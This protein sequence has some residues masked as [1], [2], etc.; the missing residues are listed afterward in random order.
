MKNGQ[1]GRRWVSGLTGLVFLTLVILVATLSVPGEK[2]AIATHAQPC[3]DLNGDGLVTLADVEI[4]ASYILMAVP[5]APSQVD[6]NQ[7]GEITGDDIIMVVDALGATDLICQDKPVGLQGEPSPTLTPV[8]TNTQTPTQTPTQ[9]QTPTPTPFAAC[10]DMELDGAITISDISIMGSYVLQPVPPAPARLDFNGNGFIDI[11]ELVLVI[12]Q[13]GQPPVNCTGLNPIGAKPTPTPLP[14]A[15]GVPTS[16]PAPTPTPVDFCADMNLDGAVTISDISI[17]ASY[18]LQPVPPAPARLDFNGDNFIAISELVLVIGQFGQLPVNCTGLDPIGAKPTPTPTST[19]TATPTVIPTSTPTSTPTPTPVNFCADM[20]LDGAVTIS[21]I[22]IMASYVLQPVPPAPARLDFNGNAF[23]DIGELVLVVGQFGQLPVNCEG[24]DPV[25][26][27]GAPT[28]TPTTPP[29]PTPTPTPTLT[30]TPTPTPTPTPTITPTPTTTPTPT[31]TPTPTPFAACVD[32]DLL[33]GINEID[34]R[35]VASYF[36]QLAPPAP[37]RVDINGDGFVTIGDV[38]LVVQQVGNE[39][40]NCAGQVPIGFKPPPTPTPTATAT[41]TP[42]P[43]PFCADINGDGIVTEVDAYIVAS[44]FGQV[45]PPAPVTVDLNRD[46]YVTI[47]DISFVVSQV[48][49][50]TACQNSPAGFNG[51]PWDVDTSGEVT[52]ID[53]RLVLKADG[54]SPP[55]NLL[56]DVNGDG[57]VSAADALLVTDHFGELCS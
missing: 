11:S 19:P 17:M 50:T 57:I 22:S 8:P 24:L 36:G 37:D 47:S 45:V 51:C 27:K 28:P 30:L 41:P 5:A 31:L 33:N 39:P 6:L 12:G 16:T 18:V 4:V 26:F 32:M 34:V 9:T 35:I 52:I 54:Q 7:D 55:L 42:T 29:T 43:V 3:A 48:G 53:V 46:G 1:I 49:T 15:T 44:Y 40:V 13:F 21:D 10:A 25:F 2:G 20:E 38:G 56:T 23:I 14:P